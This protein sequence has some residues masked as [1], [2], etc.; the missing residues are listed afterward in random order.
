MAEAVVPSLMNQRGA[1][2]PWRA[3]LSWGSC[4]RRRRA[5]GA[6]RRAARRG[7]RGGALAAGAGGAA[8]AM[9]RCC[10]AGAGGAAVGLP[11]CHATTLRQCC[12]RAPLGGWVQG[13]TVALTRRWWLD[14]NKAASEP[15]T[16]QPVAK[17]HRAPNQQRFDASELL[18]SYAY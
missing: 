12:S 11:G 5:G 6:G 3:W 2:A 17:L 15:E 4:W 18:A 16:L 14:S 1:R 9:A 13:F 8:S 7:C 10:H